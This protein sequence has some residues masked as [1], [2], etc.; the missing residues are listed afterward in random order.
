[1]IWWMSF[2]DS[3]EDE[4]KVT[5]I[6]TWFNEQADSKRK[7]IKLDNRW[8]PVRQPQSENFITRIVNQT[9]WSYASSQN[10]FSSSQTGGFSSS[11][12][13]NDNTPDLTNNAFRAPNNSDEDWET[14]AFMTKKL[15]NWGENENNWVS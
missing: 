2:D 11:N 12:V 9:T 1:M 14:P 4:V 7:T 13:E 15:N 5:I 6:A 8:K 3:F 10:W